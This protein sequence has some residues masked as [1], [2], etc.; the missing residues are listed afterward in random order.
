[1]SLI[2]AKRAKPATNVIEFGFPS[3]TPDD[4]TFACTCGDVSLVRALLAAKANPEGF[5]RTPLIAACR[6]HEFGGVI[7]ELLIEKRAY[8]NLTLTPVLIHA[9]LEKNVPVVGTL[10]RRGAHLNSRDQGGW[11]AL[12]HASPSM[13]IMRLLERANVN[14]QNTHG[15][16]ALMIATKDDH[17]EA[18]GFLL[19]LRADVKLRNSR[20]ETALI[21]AV[22]HSKPDLVKLILDASSFSSVA[23]CDVDEQTGVLLDQKATIDQQDDRGWTALTHA[24]GQTKR[25]VELLLTRKANVDLCD[26]EQWTPLMHAARYSSLET[27]ALLLSGNPNV[28]AQTKNGGTALM[29]AVYGSESEAKVQLL[30]ARNANVDAED[31]DGWTALTFAVREPKDTTVRLLQTQRASPAR[32]L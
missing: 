20:G 19:G 2:E 27:V 23:A 28:N 6:N 14:L 7:A 26:N 17:V 11:T 1:M 32:P 3:P 25:T 8:L 21:L 10:I 12:M 31:E 18:A 4:L 29:C 30:I 22:R 16:S 24:L 15:N 13:T 9:V 5:D